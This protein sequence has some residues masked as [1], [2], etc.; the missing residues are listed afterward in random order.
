MYII[1]QL[2]NDKKSRRGSSY[3]YFLACHYLFEFIYLF[4]LDEPKLLNH[5]SYI[6]K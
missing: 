2:S 5:F 3:P 1:T 6:D 4:E